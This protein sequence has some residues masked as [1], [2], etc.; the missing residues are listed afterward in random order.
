MDIAIKFRSNQ[1]SIWNNWNWV[2]KFENSKIRMAFTSKLTRKNNILKH[3][4]MCDKL[5]F[6]N[7]NFKIHNFLNDLKNV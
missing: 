7:M 3:V 6:F 5:I 1:Y 2:I 4:Q